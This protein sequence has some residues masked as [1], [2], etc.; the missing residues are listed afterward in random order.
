VGKDA[1]GKP[2][3]ESMSGM[4]GWSRDNESA[5]EST[6]ALSFGPVIQRVV[7]L[8]FGTNCAI[9]LDSGR[10]MDGRDDVEEQGADAAGF[11]FLPISNPTLIGLCCIN[12]TFAMPV[13][14]TNWD[15]G[16]ADWVRSRADKL[17]LGVKQSELPSVTISMTCSE[18]GALPSTYLFKTREGG[19]GILQLTGFTETPPA[20]KIRYKLVLAQSAELSP[21]PA[22]V[23]Q[24]N[25]NTAGFGP[26]KQVAAATAR[27]G[28][29]EARLDCLGTVES[30]N[31]V[32]FAIPETYCQKVIRKFDAHQA[33]IVE[34]DN[35]Q[36][37]RF[38]HGILVGVDN[39]IDT[40]TGTLKC[41]ASLI[42]E[43]QNLMVPGLFL[44]IHLLLEVKHGVILVPVNAIL[45]D[46]QGELV[47]VIKPDQTVSERYV[48]TGMIDGAKVEIQSGL[49][50]GEVVV[51]DG[52]YYLREGQK[53]YY[54]QVLAQASP[55]PIT[56]GRMLPPAYPTQPSD[57]QIRLKIVGIWIVD[58]NP[59][60]TV[61]NKPDG[62]F[63]TH[64]GTELT[65]EG[66]W[67]VKDGFIVATITN[68]SRLNGTVEVESNKVV[69]I[70]DYKMV[71]LSSQGGTIVLTAHKR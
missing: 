66:T 31:S 11:G 64:E 36:G 27:N 34:A 61:E 47:W 30:S 53:V 44:N 28:D 69:S 9:D 68:A 1:K 45:R 32:S 56:P 3:L 67:Q 59:S 37:E 5:V 19:R 55:A 49:S 17:P 8:E 18:D 70:D 7:N 58:G 26:G 41:R 20:V 46:P 35:H 29:I 24:A 42:P 43:G 23:V 60:R 2:V 15:N 22:H 48:Q 65:A 71:I 33:L 51:T 16:G 52:S 62:S 63:V 25:T 50:A 13:D 14:S 57:E 54:K 39:R 10:L 4:L 6:Y 40:E 38:G 12:E 21:Q